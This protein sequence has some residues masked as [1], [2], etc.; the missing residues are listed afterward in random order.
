M[1]DKKSKGGASPAA[2]APPPPKCNY[3]RFHWLEVKLY[4]D[5]P[6]H[7]DIFHYLRSIGQYQGCHILHDSDV[8]KDGNL[9]KPHWHVTL[10]SDN[11]QVTGVES[12]G[13]RFLLKSWAASFGSFEAI[14]NE[15]GKPVVYLPPNWAVDYPIPVKGGKI[16]TFQI[17][18]DAAG[19]NDP[20]QWLLYMTHSDYNS[21]I[22]GKHRYNESDLVIWDD[23]PTI[24]NQL[25]NS[26][27]VSRSLNYELFE[28]ADGV[29]T[30]RELLEKLYS[31]GRLDLVDYIK[32]NPQFVSKFIIPGR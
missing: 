27:T 2:P 18:T 15:F 28:F 10:Y 20:S 7:V 26:L 5:N 12:G 11:R 19:V 17:L 9:D 30:G 8:K 16:K 32:K 14:V 13:G 4:C 31:A 22:T 25:S 6:Y 1:S 3:K 21:I 29:S 23:S 24:R